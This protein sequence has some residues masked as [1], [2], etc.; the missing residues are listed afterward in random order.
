M[1]IDG[2][3]RG[4]KQVMTPGMVDAARRGLDMLGLSR[5]TSGHDLADQIPELSA[6]HVADAKLYA[7]RMDALDFLPRGGVVAELGVAQG[8]FSQAMLD[9]LAPAR[10]DAYDIFR[11]H[12]VDAFW[13]RPTRELL[14]GHVHE[15]FYRRRFAPLIETGRVRVFE[16]DSAEQLSHRPD[17]LYDVIY[18]DADHTGESV[19]RDAEVAARKLKADGILVFN[20]YILVDHILGTPYGI[21][22]VVNDFCVNRGWRVV[23]YALNPQLFC[24]IAI[25]R[26]QAPADA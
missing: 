23:Y 18:I 26:M 19:R 25:T 6:H 16:G 3:K 7:N 14:G 24:D 13:G 5:S 22:P 17:D 8:D 11:M 15:D 9:R 1:A 12:E 20:D 4:L 2:L 10:F 21:V